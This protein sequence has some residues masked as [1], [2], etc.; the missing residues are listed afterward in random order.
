MISS[1]KNKISSPRNRS[2]SR[3]RNNTNEKPLSIETKMSHK[4]NGK[5]E[6]PMIA[7]LEKL[8]LD[9]QAE[10]I[11]MHNYHTHNEIDAREVGRFADEPEYRMNHSRLDFINILNGF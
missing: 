10:P 5:R 6:D 3:S 1:L 9:N 8:K 4:T 2:S 7:N 11:N